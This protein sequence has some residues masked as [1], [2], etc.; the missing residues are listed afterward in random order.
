M[1]FYKKCFTF[2]K[3]C[4][5]IVIKIKDYNNFKK[6][7]YN[8]F[9]VFFYL[10]IIIEILRKFCKGFIQNFLLGKNI[11]KASRINGKLN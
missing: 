5:V 7:N 8:W 6:N 4:E 11:L 3:K 10:E 1:F 2:I 9:Q